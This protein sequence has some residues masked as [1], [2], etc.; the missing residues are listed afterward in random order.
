[1]RP[2][3]RYSDTPEDHQRVSLS[4]I[5]KETDRTPAQAKKLMDSLRFLGI[6]P[7]IRSSNWDEITYDAGAVEIAKALVRAP[8]RQLPNTESWLDTYVKET[9]D[10]QLRRRRPGG[11]WPP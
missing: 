8:H 2:R 9:P 6:F 11:P 4:Q 1:M 5:A 3:K 10:E 7:R